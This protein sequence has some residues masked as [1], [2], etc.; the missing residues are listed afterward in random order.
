VSVDV[1]KQ[2]D[3][4]GFL[5]DRPEKDRLFDVPTTNQPTFTQDIHMAKTGKQ[6]SVA[7]LER[8]LSTHKTRLAELLKKRTKLQKSGSSD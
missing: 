6:L 8:L 4:L 3:I 2:S 7:Q 5:N 1:T